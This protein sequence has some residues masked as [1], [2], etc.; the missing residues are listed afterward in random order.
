MK[1]EEEESNESVRFHDLSS[2]CVHTLA[3]YSW[4]STRDI[5]P[6]LCGDKKRGGKWDKVKSQRQSG[7]KN[8]EKEK[9][10][11]RKNTYDYSKQNKI[12]NCLT[13]W[14]TD[15]SVSIALNS[16]LRMVIWAGVREKA[17]A[18]NI[19]FLKRD[20][21]INRPK[22]FIWG[23]AREGRRESEREREW[24]NV[25]QWMRGKER[26]TTKIGQSE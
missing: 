11:D 5:E 19:S 24:V 10:S 15:L 17:T 7:E 2:A 6:L 14:L 12:L 9:Y 22:E 16:A 21:R 3:T 20:S 18:S 4:S 25:W 26:V 13:D 1:Y 23:C 8:D